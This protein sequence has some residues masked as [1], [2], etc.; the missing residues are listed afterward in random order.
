MTQD[1]VNTGRRRFLVVATS[2]MGAVAAAGVAVPFV[3]SWNPSEKA[4][5]IGAPVRINVAN[6]AEGELVTGQ[7]RGKPIFIVKRKAEMMAAL[8]QDDLKARL[9]DANSEVVSQQPEWAANDARARDGSDLSVLIGI[10][11][12][13]GCSPQFV[14]EVGPQ[15]YDRN[16]VGGYF[17]PC[18]GSR[19]DLSG[20]VFNGSPAA[21]NLE[22]PPYYIEDNVLTVGVE[23]PE[24]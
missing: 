19:F 21:T 18:H 3:R 5:A 2:A 1:G 15:D 10:C 24:A 8:S 20:R 9:K 16:W 7:W 6:V 4:K 17:C 23:G 12:H 11:T 13:L 22:V 14:P